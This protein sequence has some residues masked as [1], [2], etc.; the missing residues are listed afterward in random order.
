MVSFI[1]IMLPGIQCVKTWPESKYNSQA[2]KLQFYLFIFSFKDKI[3]FIY[4]FIQ[5]IIHYLR[6]FRYIKGT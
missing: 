3:Q 6:K 2:A 4:V 1:I 5:Q